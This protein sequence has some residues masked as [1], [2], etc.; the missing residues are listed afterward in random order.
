MKNLSECSEM[1]TE[2]NIGKI[3][4]EMVLPREPEMYHGW[5]VVRSPI[6][7]KIIGYRRTS[8]MTA[9]EIDEKYGL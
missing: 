4:F 6:T 2:T 1:R 8:K 3:K 7:D 5:E 9:R